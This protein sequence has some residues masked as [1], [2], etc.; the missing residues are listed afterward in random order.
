MKAN[1]YCKL[2]LSFFDASC[3]VD[4]LVVDQ[5]L[6]NSDIW[7]SIEEI[8]KCATVAENLQRNEESADLKLDEDVEMTDLDNAYVLST[9]CTHCLF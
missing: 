1:E 8:S 3:R 4:Q 5:E 2:L 7:K 9:F 6:K